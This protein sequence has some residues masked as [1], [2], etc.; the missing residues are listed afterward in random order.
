MTQE[1]TTPAQ[2]IL[3]DS[4]GPRSASGDTGSASAHSLPDRQGAVVFAANTEAFAHKRHGGIRR[5][6]MIPGNPT[7]LRVGRYRDRE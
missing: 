1:Q 7:G 5:L 2:Q 6:R 3:N 4:T